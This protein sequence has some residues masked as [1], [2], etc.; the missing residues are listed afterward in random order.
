[1][2]FT[3]AGP[4]IYASQNNH[5]RNKNIKD[6]R[7]YFLT[8][9]THIE[10]LYDTL[11]LLWLFIL[12]GCFCG[13]GFG[14]IQKQTMVDLL[15]LLIGKIKRGNWLSPH[16]AICSCVSGFHLDL[17]FSWNRC[18]MVTVMPFWFSCSLI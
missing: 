11:V 7:A 8:K 16:Y 4:I 15:I 18:S 13:L 12:C 6:L 10:L 9:C 2:G 3:N 1:M 14:C 17:V 5:W